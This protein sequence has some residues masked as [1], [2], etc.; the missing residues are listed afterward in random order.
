MNV[1]NN[2]KLLKALSEETR[3]KIVEVLLKGEKCACEIPTLI[4]KTQSNTSMHLSKL[5][6]LGILKSRRD[7]KMI[8]Y[9]IKNTKV[10]NLFKALGYP[11]EKLL[12]ANCCT[13]KKNK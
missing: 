10:Y 7:G 11:K 13:D 3:Y 4:G 9:S 12:K 6:D 2:L 1:E 8:I 5:S